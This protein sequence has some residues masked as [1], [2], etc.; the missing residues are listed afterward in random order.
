MTFLN[1]IRRFG[2]EKSKR[3]K[4]KS[5]PLCLAHLVGFCVQLPKELE[6][7]LKKYNAEEV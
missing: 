3:L 2:I 1:Q 5:L 6:G 4:Q 7:E